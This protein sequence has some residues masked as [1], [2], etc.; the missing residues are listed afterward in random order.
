M[1]NRLKGVIDKVTKVGQ[2]GYTSKKLCQE[3]LMGILGGMDYVKTRNKKMAL[4]SLD[5]KKAF[6]SVSHSFLEKSL[7]FFNFGPVFIR[8]IRLLCTG[9]E[10]CIILDVNKTG[11]NFKLECGNAQGD[12][13]SPFLFNICYQILILKIETSL[14]IKSVYTNP[15]AEVAGVGA[16]ED[17]E[18][19]PGNNHQRN[20]VELLNRKVYAFADDCNIITTQDLD[21]I[22]EIKNVLSN[23]KSLSGLECNLEKTNCYRMIPYTQSNRI[24]IYDNDNDNYINSTTTL[25]QQHFYNNI[26]TTTFLHLRR[27]Q[28]QLI[29][30]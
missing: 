7:E 19:V 18:A 12:T 17:G 9:R 20:Q 27:H 3:A 2:M 5:I 4:I 8:W 15:A 16:G 28:Q 23:Y 6:D 10:A 30:M 14:Q 26:T 11:K 21:S 22:N 29:L 1:T 24:V 13:I 25:Q